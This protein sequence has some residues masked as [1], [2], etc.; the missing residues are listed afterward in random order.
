M[1]PN[2][3]NLFY[4]NLSPEHLTWLF[5]LKDSFLILSIPLQ[6]QALL[7]ISLL[8]PLSQQECSHHSLPHFSFHSWWR[9]F[10]THLNW[11][12][13]NLHVS[14]LH[15]TVPLQSLLFPHGNSIFLLLTF[16]VVALMKWIINLIILTFIINN[17]YNLNVYSWKVNIRSD[18]NGKNGQSGRDSLNTFL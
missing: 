14:P 7:L 10:V 2:H 12:F 16:H 18:V 17:N 8:E 1:C 15:L 3:L 6:P 9:C 13:S 11:N 4:L 5:P